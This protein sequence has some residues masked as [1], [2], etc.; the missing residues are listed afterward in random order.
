[1]PSA[2]YP[3]PALCRVVSQQE[4]WLCREWDPWDTPGCVGAP[5][6]VCASQQLSDKCS[7]PVAPT[8]SPDLIKGVVFSCGT[9]GE[10]QGL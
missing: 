9:Q 1:M 4:C 5:L 7:S 10:I 3:D 6:E 2:L 8:S